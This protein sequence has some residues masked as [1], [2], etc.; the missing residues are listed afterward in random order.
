MSLL[1]PRQREVVHLKSC[2][3]SRKEIAKRMEISMNTVKALLHESRL[4]IG[5]NAFRIAVYRNGE[6]AHPIN[7]R[8]Y[9]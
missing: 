5:E 2:G 4:K 9:D 8:T 3:L 1:S 7:E 6:Q